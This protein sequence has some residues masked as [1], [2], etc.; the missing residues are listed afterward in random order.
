MFCK[1]LLG[2][3]T[4]HRI[5]NVTRHIIRLVKSSIIYMLPVTMFPRINFL[6]PTR[7]VSF[8]IYD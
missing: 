8:P 1:L 6:P 3:D 4:R 5:Y 7:Q 2:N